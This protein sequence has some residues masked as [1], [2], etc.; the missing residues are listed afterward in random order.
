MDSLEQYSKS[1]LQLYCI[2][3][4]YNHRWQPRQVWGRWFLTW[5]QL[6]GNPFILCFHPLCSLHTR[7]RIITIPF[8][9]IGH[10]SEP[11]CKADVRWMARVRALPFSNGLFY[12]CLLVNLSWSSLR[13]RSRSSGDALALAWWQHCQKYR[14]C[15]SPDLSLHFTVFS[16]EVWVMSVHTVWSSEISYHGVCFEKEREVQNRGETVCD[17]EAWCKTTSSWLNSVWKTREVQLQLFRGS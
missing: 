1:L 4:D 13:N 15:L 17:M 5:H 11:N 10:Y 2:A 14:L 16:K 9:T 6:Q 12:F 7:H 3:L 8:F